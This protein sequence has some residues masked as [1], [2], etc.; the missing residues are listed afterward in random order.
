MTSTFFGATNSYVEAAKYKSSESKIDADTDLVFIDDIQSSEKVDSDPYDSENPVLIHTDDYSNSSLLD[1]YETTEQT[2]LDINEKQE[3]TTISDLQSNKDIR[4]FASSQQVLNNMQNM[5]EYGFIIADNNNFQQYSH[6]YNSKYNI[7]NQRLKEFEKEFSQTIIDENEIVTLD[8][9]TKVYHFVTQNGIPSKYRFS[10]WS[11]YTNLNSFKEYKVLVDQYENRLIEPLDIPDKDIINNDLLRTFPSNFH[12]M[13]APNIDRNNMIDTLE[14]QLSIFSIMHKKDIGYC[15]SLNYLCGLVLLI[16]P[17][18]LDDSGYRRYE[19]LNT[20]VTKIGVSFYDN[21]LS[22][23][24]KFQETLLLLIHEYIPDLFSVIV[25][26]YDYGETII[27]SILDCDDN[28]DNNFKRQLEL[29]VLMIYL[30]KWVLNCFINILP[31]EYCLRVID[32]IILTDE[33]GV[34][35]IY[36]ITMVLLDIAMDEFKKTT[37]YKDNITKSNR[38]PERKLKHSLSLKLNKVLNHNLELNNNNKVPNRNSTSFIRRRKKNLS[39]HSDNSL[40]MEFLKLLTDMFQQEKYSLLEFDNVILARL[41]KSYYNV[42]D[43]PKFKKHLIKQRMTKKDKL[44]YKLKLKKI[45]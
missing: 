34:I 10:L 16:S 3:Q 11:K 28:I 6:W 35:W 40:E 36:K 39:F 37:F 33:E 1:M 26:D 19:L 5:T 43:L 31:F 44:K 18:N 24:K 41:K 15:Q 7:E 17:N 12:F 2:N 13:K 30:S 25:T 8:Y 20:L 9:Q 22:G 14:Q 21:S 38:Q 32:L 27:D 42:I 29:P 23:L 45:D 4:F